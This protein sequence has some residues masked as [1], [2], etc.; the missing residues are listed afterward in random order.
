[1]SL[2]LFVSNLLIHA[3]NYRAKT[4]YCLFFAFFALLFFVTFTLLLDV[5]AGTFPKKRPTRIKALTTCRVAELMAFE[6]KMFQTISVANKRA[7]R[8]IVGYGV[9]HNSRGRV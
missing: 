4:I 5:L 2:C 6:G 7:K 3:K 8:R 9:H 1:M